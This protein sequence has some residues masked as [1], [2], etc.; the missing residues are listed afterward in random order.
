MSPSSGSIGVCFNGRLSLGL[1]ESRSVLPL[2]SLVEVV[3]NRSFAEV[4]VGLRKF[5]ASSS[6]SGGKG[7]TS[8]V[9]PLKGLMVCWQVASGGFGNP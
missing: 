7:G 4:L 8:I 5:L 9:S 3:G 6:S 2:K 1:G